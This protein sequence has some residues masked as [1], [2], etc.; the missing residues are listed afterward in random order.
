MSW[1]LCFLRFLDTIFLILFG[2][3]LIFSHL[4]QVKSQ[5][6]I[7]YR[8]AT[9]STLAALMKQIGY[10]VPTRILDQMRYSFH[11]YP[12]VSDRPVPRPILL[13]LP[14]F[15]QD[16]ATEDAGLPFFLSKHFIEAQYLLGQK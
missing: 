11:Q 14:P 3:C 7:T 5:V 8:N 1:L 13:T 16:V 12:Q 15:L 4:E 2:S 10:S 6:V 9:F